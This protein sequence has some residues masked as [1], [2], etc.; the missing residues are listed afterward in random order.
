MIETFSVTRTSF[1]SLYSLATLGSA[2]LIPFLGGMIDTLK[3]NLYCYALAFLFALSV[4]C[5]A[6]SQSLLGMGLGILGVRLTGQGLMSHV[7]VTLTARYFKEDRGKA[8]AVVLLGHSLGEGVLPLIFPLLIVAFG[9]RDALMS[10]AGLACIF[11]VPTIFF[12]S[13]KN[14]KFL[15]PEYKERSR[16]WLKGFLDRFH[17]LRKNGFLPIIPAMLV[18]PFVLTAVFFH[19]SSLA[20]SKSWDF[21]WLLVCF[22][23][24]ALARVPS[25]I[26]F[27]PLIDKY[28]AGK[29]VLIPSLLLSVG[30]G[31]VLLFNHPMVALPY[32]AFCGISMGASTPIFS[33]LL[34]ERVPAAQYG[35]VKS[36]ISPLVVFST[37]ISP[38]LVGYSLD[39]GLSFSFILLGLILVS[40]SFGL[41]AYMKSLQFNSHEATS[42]V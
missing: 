23:S 4:V 13:R 29:L 25:G 14:P 32:L 17:I 12:L 22:V 11:Y 42:P 9:W 8:L 19:A 5:L 10:V 6:A 41:L 2:L 39:R 24:F 21:T 15:T 38:V 33:A 31:F 28:T 18:A 7:S 26:V 40:I 34:A 3:A 30:L 35:Q 27:G 37:A 36:V 20:A 1:S 16:G